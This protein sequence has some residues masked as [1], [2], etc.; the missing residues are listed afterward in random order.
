VDVST[1]PALAHMA[2]EATEDRISQVVEFSG[3][4]RETA[5]RYLRVRFNH[6]RTVCAVADSEA[7]R[8]RTTMFRKP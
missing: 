1:A 4:D 3:C 5:A 8:S 6:S 2:V 7:S